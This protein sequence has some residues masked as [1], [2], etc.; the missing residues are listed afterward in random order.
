MIHISGYV[1]PNTDEY[2]A[3]VKL[4]ELITTSWPI[5]K[6]SAQDHIYIVVGAK[7]HGQ[8]V[9]DVDLLVLATFK[10]ELTYKPYLLFINRDGEP[11][12]PDEVVIHSFCLAIEIKTHSSPNIRFSGTNVDVYYH[13]SR[14]WHNASQQNEE[15]KQSIINYLKLQGFSKT[16]WITPLIWL[17]NVPSVDLPK[18][19]HNILGSEANWELFVNVIGQLHAPENRN[20]KWVLHAGLESRSIIENIAI[21]LTKEINPTN[22]DRRRMEQINQQLSSEL[23]LSDLVGKKLLILRGRGGTGKTINLLQLAKH[24]YDERAARV[25]V[26]TYNRALVADLRRLMTIMGIGDGYAE[27]SI[28]IQTIHSFFYHIMKT[29]GVFSKGEDEFLQKYSEFKKETLDLLFS[30]AIMYEDI[31]NLIQSDTNKFAWDFVFVDEGQDWPN[32]EREILFK[33]FGYNFFTIADGIDQLVREQT[34]ANWRGNLRKEQYKIVPLKR[35]LRMKAGITACISSFAS[36][37]GLQQSE[38]EANELIP[39]GRI[40]IYEN[41]SLG[42][43]ERIIKDV[44]SEAKIAGNEPVDLLFCVPSTMASSDALSS[45]T[46]NSVPALFQSWG[47]KIWDGTSYSGR[48]MYPTENDQLRIVQYESCRGLEG[49]SVVLFGFDEFYSRKLSQIQFTGSKDDQAKLQAAR[50]LMIP[51]T[52]AMDTLVIHLSNKASIVKDVLGD[53]ASSHSALIEWRRY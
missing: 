20:G 34:L 40:L 26:L 28:Q 42:S 18:R 12:L 25:L 36:E 11:E 17:R 13:K 29:L 3:A 52:R 2:Q 15:Q 47:L 31:Q 43:A 44:I 53:L 39:G 10:S 19:P 35:C 37:F 14:K 22:L 23:E 33:L 27:K 41:E 38:W 8:A 48:E 24:L 1:D 50:W 6:N 4:Q 51:L 32:D 21:A 49:W 16:P 7:C 5:L 9:R 46:P 45:I 30:G